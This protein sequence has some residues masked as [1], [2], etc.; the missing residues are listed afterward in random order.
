MNGSAPMPPSEH[1]TDAELM[2]QIAGGSQDA[3]DA[4][5]GRFARPILALAA[6]S[7]DRATAEDVVQDVFLA[8]WRHAGTFDETRGTLR[9]WIFQIAHFRVLNEL[10]RRS[11]QPE[12]APDPDG[13]LLASLPASSLGPAEATA[14][15][16]RRAALRTA[17]DEL[18]PAQR[19]AVDL[20][21]F[22]DLSHAQV[23]AELDLPLGTAKTRIRAGLQSLR[24][25]LGP[26]WAA[27]V[28]LALLAGLGV[29]HQR[30]V[31]EQYDRALSM[32]TASDS[33]SLRLGPGSGMP[34]AAHAR[35]RGRP[36]ATVA[37][38]T[39]SAFP[40]APAGD[41]YQ[42]WTR[43]GL[44]WTSL[45]TVRPDAAGGGRLIAEGDVIATLPDAL[46]VTVEPG[47]GSAAP[48]GRIAAE[49]TR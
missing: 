33:V 27:V 37:V 21:F 45:G 24:G 8:V 38:V 4:L 43:H 7:L 16:R 6:Q 41:T 47:A 39:L 1:A 36:G 17:V 23:A 31:L 35:Y 9:A 40:P 46:E 29:R 44:T 22:D 15:A 28:A 10:R 2:R 32:V 25:R 12:I 34:E 14:A 42:V 48:S 13:R 26:Q 11:R 30:T 49:W 20:A 3:L 5:H 18:P 19:E